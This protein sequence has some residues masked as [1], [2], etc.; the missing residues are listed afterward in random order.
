ML[1]LNIGMPRSGTL[2]R[3]NIVRDFV[4]AGGGKDGLEI[5]QKYLLF[6]FIELPSADINTTKTK[7]LFPAA[8][9]SF[10]GESY[11]LNTHSKPSKYASNLIKKGRLKAVYGYRDPRDC[12]L[13]ILE[14]GKNAPP[15][16]S[17]K[18]LQVKS[19]QQA[20]DYM[21]IYINI[22]ETWINQE[23]AYV[24]RYE[25]MLVDYPAFIDQLIQY[26]EVDI[27]PE[28]REKISNTYR[29]KQKA[30]NNRHI[31]FSHGVAHRFRQEFTEEEQAYLLETY[32]PILERMGYEA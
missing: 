25:D 26:L 13:S 4:M 29:P 22:W 28:Q 32:S 17:N 18:F 16:F 8:I 15:Q 11:V 6:P 10:L 23:G 24:M 3:Y 14:Y 21:K 7:R 19:V 20:V 5:R 9:P 1:F 27:S 31:H 2:W 12:I 30:A